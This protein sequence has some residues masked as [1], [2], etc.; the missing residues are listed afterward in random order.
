[1]DN[2]QDLKEEIARVA[3]EIY[4][5]TGISGRDVENWLEAERIV[6][7]RLSVM[8][9]LQK[10]LQDTNKAI[11][12]DPES[13]FAY[14][15]R[16]IIY[17]GLRRYQEAIVDYNKAIELDE[18]SVHAYS[19]RGSVYGILGNYKKCIEDTS[20][21]IELDPK[22]NYPYYSRGWAYKFLGDETSAIRD[23]K[24]SAKLGYK[25]AQEIL[26]ERGIELLDCLLCMEQE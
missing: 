12:S 15:A 18:R 4:E 14:V 8:D 20:K 9:N 6:L 17:S 5:R 19:D 23:W 7:E 13:S 21:A 26:K 3:R 24:I 22:Y 25:K 2:Q 10:A 1:V 16:G 11:E